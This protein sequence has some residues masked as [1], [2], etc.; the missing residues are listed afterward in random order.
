MER[1][2]TSLNPYILPPAKLASIQ[3]GQPTRTAVRSV[4]S[5]TFLAYMVEHAAWM[6]CCRLCRTDKRRVARHT[7]ELPYALVPPQIHR[8]VREESWISRYGA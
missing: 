3:K 5:L 7:S 6:V 1:T 4:Q 8:E 2:S